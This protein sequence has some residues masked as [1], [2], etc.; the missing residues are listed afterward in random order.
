MSKF[1]RVPFWHKTILPAT[2]EDEVSQ[3]EVL[4]KLIHKINEIID[5]LNNL[6]LDG[7]LVA[8]RLRKGRKIQLINEVLGSTIFDGSKDVVIDALINP[9]FVNELKQ[10]ILDIVYDMIQD[11]KI[12][13]EYIKNL[14]RQEIENI[15]YT[16]LMN[17]IENL[18]NEKLSEL[19][20]YVL[21][22]AS[23]E[24]LGGIKVGSGLGITEDGVL[25]VIKEEPPLPEQ[26]I[27]EEYYEFGYLEYEFNEEDNTAVCVGFR[28]EQSDRNVKIPNNVIK[29]D[30]SYRVIGT[31]SFTHQGMFFPKGIDS[32]NLGDNIERIEK[33]SFLNAI[34]QPNI[35]RLP[36][37]LKFIGN[38]AFYG[39]N[40]YGTLEIPEEVEE[41]EW[42]AFTGNPNLNKVIIKNDIILT[43]SAHGTPF[44]GNPTINEY[45]NVGTWEKRTNQTET[46]WGWYKVVE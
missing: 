30:V 21:P 15:D 41:I 14:I 11:N 24:T 6:G 4:A 23:F 1:E 3:Y 9:E 5:F 32:L 18:I 12:S 43:E 8:D 20:P 13:D 22:I 2:W 39:C 31:K 7:E 46:G 26:P 10:E 16:D 17:E 25:Y 38:R 45:D 35:L 44:G 37:N 29:D 28:P 40:I 36:S 33:T 19:E 34:K 27:D 42:S